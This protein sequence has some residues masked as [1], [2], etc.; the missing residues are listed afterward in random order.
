M[1]VRTPLAVIFCVYGEE[2]N[3]FVLGVGSV[4]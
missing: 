1:Q 2:W 4:G 3:V